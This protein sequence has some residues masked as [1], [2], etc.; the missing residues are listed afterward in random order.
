MIEEFMMLHGV[1]ST[2]EYVVE[3]CPSE[4]TSGLECTRD[5]FDKHK[6]HAAGTG[7]YVASVWVDL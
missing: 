4:S 6:I 2:P 5:G 1:D 3:D 7:L